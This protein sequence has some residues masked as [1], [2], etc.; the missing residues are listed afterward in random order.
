M[1][2]YYTCTQNLVRIFG[3]DEFLYKITTRIL[4]RASVHEAIKPV[5]FLQ[6]PLYIF[7]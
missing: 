5:T 2:K 1:H 6:R 3:S 4:F 7:R